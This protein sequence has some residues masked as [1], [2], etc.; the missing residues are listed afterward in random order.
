MQHSHFHLRINNKR[1]QKLKFQIPKH[2]N[3]L[4]FGISNI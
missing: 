1:A 2:S 3:E 4:E